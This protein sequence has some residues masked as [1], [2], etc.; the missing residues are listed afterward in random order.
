VI[1]LRPASDA[2]LPALRHLFAQA[3]HLEPVHRAALADLLFH[4]PP[5]DPSLR[6]VAEAGAEVVGAAFGSVHDGT[7]Y[8][9]AIAVADAHRRR[10][11][12][13][14]LLA[15]LEERL[16]AAGGTTLRAGGNTAHYAWPGIDLRY[17]PALCLVERTGYRRTG[18]AQNMT[19]ELAGWVPGER[20]DA[21]DDAVTVRR[22]RPDDPLVE[23]V[24]ER[25]SDSWVRESGIAQSRARP[26]VFVA[27]REERI[28]GFACHGVYRVDWFGPIG[29]ADAERGSGVGE[30]LL[31]RC[32]D[33][34][35]A[36]G[37]STAQISWIGPSAFYSRTVGAY[38]DRTFAS[39]EK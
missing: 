24:G 9:D 27:L 26:T 18:T 36:A 14:R 31:R 10:G 12:G 35:A 5:G 11:V 34:Q 32:L 19:V 1:D 39:F 37:L 3:L 4:R 21:R 28:V 8:V 33:E 6:L 38:C 30:A 7:G 16:R 22:A 2:D 15:E 13:G 20:I 29:V 23:F 25:F 17:T